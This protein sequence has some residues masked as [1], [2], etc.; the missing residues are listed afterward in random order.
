MFLYIAIGVIQE[1]FSKQP[2]NKTNMIVYLVILGLI[3]FSLGQVYGLAP[4][5]YSFFN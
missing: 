3:T 4:N 1:K 5:P 2:S